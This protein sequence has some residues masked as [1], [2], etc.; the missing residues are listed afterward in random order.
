VLKNTVHIFCLQVPSGFGELNLAV[1]HVARVL[2]ATEMERFNRYRIQS[3]RNDLILSRVMFQT[4]ISRLGLTMNRPW[5][6]E[7]ESNGKP[8]AMSAA[9][10]ASYHVNTS[11]T[12]GMIIWA[13]SHHGPLG[14]DAEFI[15]ED[16]DDVPVR[17][18]RR[19]S[20]LDTAPW[21]Q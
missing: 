1:D 11:D 3:R 8:Y 10:R 16:R 18:L 7:T 20:W 17:C 13:I 21:P 12:S 6:I 5:W 19:L 2:T 9:G 15:S 14:C 4:I